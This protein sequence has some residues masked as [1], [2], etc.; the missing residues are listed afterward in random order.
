MELSL[1]VPDVIEKMNYIAGSP[2]MVENIKMMLFSL[3]IQKEDII[4]E[5]FDGY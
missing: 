2:A 1:L 5:S 4:V 3:D